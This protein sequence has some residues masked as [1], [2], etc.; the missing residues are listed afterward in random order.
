MINMN[1]GMDARSVRDRLIGAWELLSIREDLPDGSVRD[2]PEFGPAPKGLLVYTPSG[3][4]SV[5][6]MR[7]DRVPWKDEETAT[8]EERA[9]A[10]AGYGGYA[11]RFTVGEEAG[12]VFVLHH[13]EVAVIPN[14][15]GSDLKRHCS[16]EGDQLTLRP[17]PVAREGG[18]IRRTLTWRRVGL[19]G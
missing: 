4:V 9:S 14:R 13:V 7:P 15:V 12:S 1:E 2:R 3:L 19:E 17:E 18:A 6:F 8:P 5:H 10:L 11:G 16:F